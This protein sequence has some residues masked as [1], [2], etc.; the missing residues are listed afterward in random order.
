MRNLIVHLI[1]GPVHWTFRGEALSLCHGG[2]VF[3]VY[4]S[5][6]SDSEIRIHVQRGM[7]AYLNVLYN[8][9]L[10]LRIGS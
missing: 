6:I 10:Y 2:G 7:Y 8:D 4:P 9:R 1:S 5:G 3:G